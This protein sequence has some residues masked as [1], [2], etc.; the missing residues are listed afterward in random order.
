MRVN[1]N[2]NISIH[3]LNVNLLLQYLHKGQLRCLIFFSGDL[4]NV[5]HCYVIILNAQDLSKAGEFHI[6]ID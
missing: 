1:V 2:C 3:H 4:L 6:N 5:I